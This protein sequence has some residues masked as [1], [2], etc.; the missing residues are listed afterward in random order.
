MNKTFR[1]SRT[2]QC[3]KCPWKVST[4]PYDIPHGYSAEKHRAMRSTIAADGDV[5][6]GGTL[7]IMACHEHPVG[8]EVPCIGW[9]ANQIGP[10]NN[11]GL[12]LWARGCENI[13]DMELDGEQHEHFEDT[14]P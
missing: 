3:D 13:R 2:K 7:R 8:K 11:I 6:L 14:L 10:G 12:R 4:D 5:R 1:L 9:L